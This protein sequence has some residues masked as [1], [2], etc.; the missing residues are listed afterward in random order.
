MAITF[1]IQIDQNQKSCCV[2]IVRN[3]VTLKTTSNISVLY[4]GH[5]D[6]HYLLT[7]GRFKVLM[8][9]FVGAKTLLGFSLFTSKEKFENSKNLQW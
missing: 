3:V 6:S 9:S 4:L 7:S 2:L 5:F 8:I 1:P